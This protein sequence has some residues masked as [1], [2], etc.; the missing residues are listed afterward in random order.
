VRQV[1]GDDENRVTLHF[2]PEAQKY[3]EEMFNAIEVGTTDG[4]ALEDVREFAGR[5]GEHVARLA[6]LFHF[7]EHW[8]TFKQL[9][10]DGKAP[11]TMAI[12][13]HTVEAADKVVGWYLKEFRRVFDPQAQM[14]EKGAYVL[15]QFKS[16]PSDTTTGRV[17]GLSY[18]AASKAASS[19]SSSAGL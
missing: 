11:K 3:W 10:E 6:A 4:G 1:D 19:C 17:I 7:F 5:C 16:L 15:N 18:P 9:V 13:K 14:H 2:D 12:P 8:D